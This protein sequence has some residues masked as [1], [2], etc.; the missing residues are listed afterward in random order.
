MCFQ[1]E[2]KPK[3][4]VTCSY[5]FSRAWRRI[6][7]FASSSDWFIG[8]S[9]SVVIGQNDYFWSWLGWRSGES[10]RLPPMWPR[11]DSWT[12]RHKWVESVV[13]SRPSSEGFFLRVHRFFLPPQKLTFL[14]SNSTWFVSTGLP[15]T[16]DC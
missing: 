2:V 16:H 14:N 4:I 6:Y 11:F 9:A 12:R 15:V 10:A 3:P 7:V 5:V 13:S 8:L 1:S